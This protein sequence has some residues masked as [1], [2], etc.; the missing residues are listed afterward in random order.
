M[1]TYLLSHCKPQTSE[2]WLH[3]WHRD[4]LVVVGANHLCEG[5]PLRASHSFTSLKSFSHLGGS[6]DKPLR[7]GLWLPLHQWGNWGSKSQSCRIFGRSQVTKKRNKNLPVWC[8]ILGGERE[9]DYVCPLPS[10]SCNKNKQTNKILPLVNTNPSS[11]NII[12]CISSTSIWVLIS[13]CWL[14]AEG[15]TLFPLLGWG[16]LGSVYAALSTLSPRPPPSRIT[17]NQG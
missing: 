3:F 8:L 4:S 12:Y 17:A 10:I 6:H 14:T 5:T 1:N 2:T 11:T 16:P 9:R 15:C 13:Y 7:G